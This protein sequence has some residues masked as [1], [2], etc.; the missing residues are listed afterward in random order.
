MKNLQ[1]LL[2]MLCSIFAF[3][4]VPQSI[5]YQAIAR[6]AAGNP[7]TNSSVAIRVSIHDGTAGGAVVYA[8]RDT[9]TTNQFGLFTSK[10]GAGNVISGTFTGINWD[11]NNKF[12]QVELDPTGGSSYIDMGTTQ[13]ISVPYALSADRALKATNMSLNELSDVSAASPTAGN[14]LGWDGTE[15]IP[16]YDNTGQWTTSGSDIYYNT[17]YVGVGTITPGISFH[18]KQVTANRALRIEHESNTNY[19]ENGIGVSTGNYK[20]YYNGAFKSDI[21]SVDGAYVQASDLRLKRDIEVMEPV[22]AKVALLK[23]YTYHYIDNAADAVRSTGFVTQDVEQVF[24]NLVRETD[25]GFKGLVYDGF[26]VI[27]IKAIQ[28]LQAEIELLKQEINSLKKK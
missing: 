8:E 24:P 2:F 22:L 9:A 26:A 17:G 14:I 25:N 3:A 16:V 12:M 13:L 21:S 11:N 20:F 6:N 7:I 15:W 10:I 18:I 28:E 1:L 19:W 5:N 4:Q 27:S 23:P